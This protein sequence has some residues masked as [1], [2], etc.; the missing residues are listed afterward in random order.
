MTDLDTLPAPQPPHAK[1]WL[2]II[3]TVLM[4]AFATVATVQWR[5]L[6][7]LDASVIYEG[8]NIVWSFFQLESE[9]LKLRNTLRD[10]DRS[11]ASLDREALQTRYDILVSRVA[12]V[13]PERT[14]RHMQSQPIQT[15]TVAQLHA[16]VA[17]ADEFLG[18]GAAPIGAAGVRTVLVRMA[19]LAQPVH[20]L[21]LWANDTMASKVG[22]R[23]AL[24]REQNHI[25]IVLTVFQSLLAIG[26]AVIVVRQWRALEQRGNALERL[27]ARLQEARRDAEAASHTKSAFLANMSHELRTPFQG[28]LGMIALAE[29]GPLNEQQAEQ[30][31]TA[32]ESAR[33]L[34][35]LLN[36]VLDLS[37]LENGQLK[38]MPVPTALHALIADVEALMD[39]PART[40][41]I[42]LRMRRDADVPAQVLADPVRLKQILF[43]LVGNAIKFTDAGTVLLETHVEDDLAWQAALCFT[44]TDTGIGMDATTVGK[45][46]Q[47]FTQGDGSTSRRF[48][49]TGLGLEISR[50]LAR[51]M[52]GDIDVRSTPGRGSCFRLRVP[53]VRCALAVPGDTA[54]P[55]D[56]AVLDTPPLRVL[57]AEDHPVNRQ[58]LHALLTRQ[59]HDVTLRENGQLAV[60]AAAQADFDVVLMDLH[61]PLM[62][63]LAATRAI[64]ALPAPRGGVPIV[65]LTADAFD[66]TRE[67]AAVAGMDDFLAKPVQP[68]DLHHSLARLFGRPRLKVAAPARPAL[69]AFAAG[70]S[71]WLDM[72]VPELI[73]ESLPA[74]THAH[75]LTVFFE[76]HS[77]SLARLG[78]ALEGPPQAE[79]RRAAHAVRGAALSLGLRRM[80]ET[81]SAIET[82]ADRSSASALGAARERFR[83]DLARSRQACIEAGWLAAGSEW[84]ESA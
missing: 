76:D 80:A 23:N 54:L 28:V 15:E 36:D 82:L 24:V 53:L 31:R 75:L 49:G 47:R 50:N 43:N 62:D 5:Q 7:L 61:M 79:L 26:L 44:V 29:D 32:R 60:E 8:D 35:S 34:L 42:E 38:L 45:L 59:G 55:G 70:V 10:I 69:L 21:A 1:R 18:P 68:S 33:H 71:A 20:D 17:A 66:E 13:E 51:M 58:V 4:A 63:G 72:S 46:F 57:V 6:R 74:G 2:W 37:T 25:S 12:L 40:K 78:L 73:F 77:G 27:A 16:F 52:G 64:R 11:P 67:R 48:G 30:L 41:G 9:Y 81:T 14:Q 65:A 83:A 56:K 84:K 39:G 19:P 3:V 22:E